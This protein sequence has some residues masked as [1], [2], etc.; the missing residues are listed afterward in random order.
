MKHKN[1]SRVCQNCTFGNNKKGVRILHKPKFRN[2]Y[3]EGHWHIYCERRRRMFKW[4]KRRF[5]GCFIRKRM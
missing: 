1:P 4:D 3:K 5:I 2:P